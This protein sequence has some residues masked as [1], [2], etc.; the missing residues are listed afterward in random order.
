MK[1]QRNAECFLRVVF[2]RCIHVAHK[3]RERKNLLFYL[4]YAV[5]KD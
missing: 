3:T 2:S 1:E 5:R 4:W